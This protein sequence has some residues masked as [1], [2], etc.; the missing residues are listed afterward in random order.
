MQQMPCCYQ[1]KSSTGFHQRLLTMILSIF[2]RM[3]SYDAQQRIEDIIA[4]NVIKGQHDHCTTI[5]NLL[6][7]SFRASRELKKDFEGK[8]RIKEEQAA[9]LEHYAEQNNLLILTPDSTLQI[10]K[11]GEAKVFYA[12]DKRSVIKADD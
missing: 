1:N 12:E 4:G 11:G 6:C 3:F 9:F 2:V 10:V 7:T 5:R 8:R